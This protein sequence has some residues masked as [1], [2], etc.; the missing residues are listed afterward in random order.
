MINVPNDARH[1]SS[2]SSAGTPPAAPSPTSDLAPSV[3]M[4]VVGATVCPVVNRASS[5]RVWELRR[6]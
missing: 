4:H 5:T 2:A 6:G 1:P 3:D